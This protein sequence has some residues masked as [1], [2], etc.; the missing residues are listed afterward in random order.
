MQDSRGEINKAWFLAFFDLAI[1]ILN[2]WVDY[3]GL[4]FFMVILSMIIAY[5]AYNMTENY[6]YYLKNK[7]D[8]E[9]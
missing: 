8:D 9:T 4:A 5:K 7:D 3:T 2:Y 1:G 6:N